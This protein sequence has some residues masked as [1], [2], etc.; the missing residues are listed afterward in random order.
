MYARSSG[1]RSRT[2]EPF[3]VLRGIASPLLERNIKTDIIIRIE[4]LRD[5]GRDQL[6]A[7][8]FEAWRYCPDGSENPDFWRNK[9]PFRNA[10]IIPGGANFGLGS[11][12]E[13]TL[14]GA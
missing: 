5:L 8:D 14:R 4:R 3:T 11:P 2:M 12:P 1:A 7:Y 6:G 13:G 9:D 10:K